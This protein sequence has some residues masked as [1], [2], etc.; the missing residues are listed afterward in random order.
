MD[1]APPMGGDIAT[2]TATAALNF[3]MAS[4][5]IAAHGHYSGGVLDRLMEAV[6]YRMLALP[7]GYPIRVGT[8]VV[9]AIGVY[10]HDLDLAH[11]LAENAVDWVLPQFEGD[12]Q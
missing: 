11:E 3:G 7:G 5:A 6:P 2:A 9:G 8:A 1:G 4:G 12:G 10:C